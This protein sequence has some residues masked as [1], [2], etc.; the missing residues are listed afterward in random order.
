MIR[1]L[2]LSLF[3]LLLS[4]TAFADGGTRDYQVTITNITQAQI[5]APVAVAT[6]GIA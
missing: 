5:F 1:T 3:G 2:T 6:H 4:V